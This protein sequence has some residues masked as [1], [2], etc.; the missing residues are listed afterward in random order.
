LKNNV[1]KSRL[2]KLRLRK[3]VQ[4]GEAKPFKNIHV[5]FYL[6]GDIKEDKAAKAAQ[7]LKILFGFQNRTNGNHTHR[8]LNEAPNPKG[9][10][11][12]VNETI[13]IISDSAL[14]RGLGG[15]I[16]T[17]N[18]SEFGF[19][20]Q[21]IRNQLERTQYLEILCRCISRLV[22]YLKM[23]KTCASFAE[24]KTGIFTADTATQITTNLLAKY[25]L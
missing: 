3:R 21:A 23:P 8:V 22:L 7:L 6:E 24:E 2:S 12:I 18:N 10:P 15:I 5:V 16:Y 19:E 11:V 25:A 17:M 4:V 9:E 14:L 20:T 1:K 13:L